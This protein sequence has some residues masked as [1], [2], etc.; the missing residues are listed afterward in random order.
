MNMR[1]HLIASS[2]LAVLPCVAAA[3]DVAAS[4]SES[5]YML[6]AQTTAAEDGK[7]LTMTL[8]E[9]KRTPDFSIVDV[10]FVSGGSASSLFLVR[11]LCGVMLARGQ[12]F[13]V[14]EQVSEHPIEF[15]M[16]FPNSTKVEDA[17]GLPRMVLSES[18]CTRIQG[19]RE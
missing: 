14:A 1:R 17:K 19:R 10:E 13:A 4:S 6:S 2:L 8:R 11:G 7:P 15:R 5:L 18:D 16:T 12:K 3:A 9:T